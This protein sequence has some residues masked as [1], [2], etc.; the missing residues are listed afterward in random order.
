MNDITMLVAKNLDLN[1]AWV[2]TKLFD[3]NIGLAEAGLG[4]GARSRQGIRQGSTG[5]NDL[6]PPSATAGRCFDN[7]RVTD[8]I[9]NFLRGLGGCNTVVSARKDRHASRSHCLTG[10]D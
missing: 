8:V 4:L 1:V 3:V 10:A 2:L 7:H 9:G 6:H 5:M